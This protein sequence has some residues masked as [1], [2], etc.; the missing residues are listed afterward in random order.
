MKR[1]LLGAALAAAVPVAHAADF[2]IRNETL[3][4]IHRL[5]ISSSDDNDWGPDQLEDDILRSGQSLKLGGVSC[6][7]Y[8]V[9]MI[10]EDGDTCELR[11]VKMCGDQAWTLTNEAWLQCVA[12]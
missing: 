4:D 3:W 8:D 10:D 2:T 11:G 12:D 1:W 5:Y 7:T 6:D 9:K